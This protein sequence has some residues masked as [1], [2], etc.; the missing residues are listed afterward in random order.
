[1]A[2]RG[3]EEGQ[4]TLLITDLVRSTDLV[5]ELGDLKSAGVFA[6]VEQLIRDRLA[7]TDGLEIDKT[8]GFLLL[9][10]EPMTAIR[11]ALH[12]HA[13]LA[14]LADTLG[15]SLQVR[16]GI[17]V[18]HTI[19]R[20]NAPAAVARGAKPVEVE[21]IVKPTTARIMTLAH[22]GQTLI[23]GVTHAICKLSLIHI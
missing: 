12:M 21:G 11:F 1:M 8:D 13:D 2:G 3:V 7:Q 15:L 20:H 5:Q 23:S 4:L 14:H 22:G 17:H 19:L 18:G 6:Q 9:F 10:Q 16:C